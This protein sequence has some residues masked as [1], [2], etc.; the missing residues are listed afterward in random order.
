MDDSAFQATLRAFSAGAK[1]TGAAIVVDAAKRFGR[2]A[3]KGTPPLVGGKKRKDHTDFLKRRIIGMRLPRGKMTRAMI[4]DRH[5]SKVEARAYLRVALARQ[6]EMLA[7][8]NA[9]ASYSG[10]RPAQWIARHGK[11]HGRIRV[12]GAGIGTSARVEFDD[13]ATNRRFNMQRFVAQ[14]AERVERGLAANRKFSNG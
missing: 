3:L 9:L 14:I 11:K 2:L 12:S 6:G 1:K 13:G 7:G 8:W 10:L 4:R 5:M